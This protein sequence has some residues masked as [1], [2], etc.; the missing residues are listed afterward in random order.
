[1]KLRNFLAMMAVAFMATG[2]TSCDDDDDA[3]AGANVSGDFYG[4]NSLSVAGSTSYDSTC[5][6][7]VI[8]QGN[9]KY[10]LVLPETTDK[11]APAPKG[12]PDMPTFTIK[13]IT[14]TETEKGV[15]TYNAEKIT[16]DVMAGKKAVISNLKFN[17]NHGAKTLE[18]SYGLQFGKM[19]LTIQYT[20]KTLFKNDYLVGDFFGDNA[21]KVGGKD[22]SATNCT[23]VIE[24]QGNGKYALVLP[25]AAKVEKEGRAMDLPTI[26]IADLTVTEDANTYSFALENAVIDAGNMKITI[27]NLKG[28]VHGNKLNLT[29]DMQPGKMPMSISN[30]FVGAKIK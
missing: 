14:L 16:I 11:A 4:V 25:E 2:F 3:I 27:K 15:Y 17:L 24:A 22:M 28:N 6:A 10:S 30:N 12:M 1:M 19:P 18:L 26:K 23:A 5:V 20:F 29:Y 9:G 21:M 7:H 13:D 8:N